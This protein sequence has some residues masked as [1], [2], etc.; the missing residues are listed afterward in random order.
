[1]DEVHLTEVDF[2][3]GGSHSEREIRKAADIFAAYKNRGRKFPVKAAIIEACFRVAFPDSDRLRT[4]T[5]KPS[6]VAQYTRHAD[7]VIVERWLKSR[8]FI[9]KKGK[10]KDEPTVT[11]VLVGT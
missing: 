6:N 5:I 2:L 1:M 9:V 7:S 3:R 8:G 11:A 10:A 4:V